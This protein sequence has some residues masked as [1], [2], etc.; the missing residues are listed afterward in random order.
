MT[1]AH[2]PLFLIE[3]NEINFE[4]VE[5]YAAKGKLP[6]LARLISKHGITQTTSE[7]EYE[8]LE[9]WI[10]WITAHTGLSYAEHQVFRL[11]DIT[12]HE[13][14]QIWEFLETHGLNVGAVSP[15][16]AN[17]RLKNPAFFV[18]DPWT[19]TPASGGIFLRGL[20]DAAAQAVNDNAKSRIT[21]K[22]SFWLLA[23]AVRYARP[24]N[25]GA[26]VSLV[27]GAL[28]KKSWAKAQFL[29]QLLADVMVRETRTKKPQFVSLFLNAGAHIQHHYMFNASV[30][31]GAQ[32]NPEW[33]LTRDDD[34]IFDIYDQYDKSVGQIMRAFPQARL[35]IA[36]GLHQ[37]PFGYEKYYWR[38]KDHAHFLRMI[39]V[40]FAFV[41]PRMSRDFLIE[42]NDA[43]QA[44]TAQ[45]VLECAMSADGTALFEVDNRGGS[46]FVMLTYPSD[47]PSGMPI[48]VGDKIYDDLRS[49]VAFVAIKNGEHN[50]I[51]Y[52]I[53]TGVN[54]KGDNRIALSSLPARIADA[55]GLNWNAHPELVPIAAE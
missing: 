32:R 54:V 44:N 19:E 50:G 6:H 25:Y 52:L 22:S 8:H 24:V 16:N 31:D 46:L 36:T 51:G 53:D 39:G 1:S 18:P 38:L 27:M 47:I 4:F 55:F 5:R 20:S 13:I 12:Q 3:L 11:G 48:K 30:Y 42:C 28:K 34:P 37:D 29:D 14:P 43:A 9:P 35:M 10:Q 40:P 21:P 2:S 33:L 26:Y 7:D 45:Q 15:M 23:G 41:E 49:H 17:N